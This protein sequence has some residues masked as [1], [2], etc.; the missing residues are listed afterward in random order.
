MEEREVEIHTSAGP[1]KLMGLTHAWAPGL[2]VTMHRFGHFNVTH[3][4]SGMHV[5]SK[6]GFERFWS[7]VR[8][9]LTLAPMIDWTADAKNVAEQ[10]K[11]KSGEPMPV[12]NGKVTEKGVERRMTV[13][14]YI[15]SIRN[16]I[17][18]DEFPWEGGD[19]P[20]GDCSRLLEQIDALRT[21]ATKS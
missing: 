12:G 9:M 13:G 2:A 14:E 11:A 7:A 4:A 16:W 18:G 3:L 8:E 21:G 1:R 20:K 10:I 6:Q 17:A 19:G 5:D 15:R